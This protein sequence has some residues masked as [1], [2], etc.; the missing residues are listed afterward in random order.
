MAAVRSKDTTPELVVRRLVHAM[1]FRYRLHVES[2]PGC[3]DLVFPR[4]RKVILVNGCFWHMHTCRRSRIPSSRRGYWVKKLERNAS[5]DKRNLRLL[6][7]AG[8][9]VLVAWECQ[10]SRTKLARLKAR[11]DSFLR[12]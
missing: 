10:T 11:I 8:W 6:R 1:G 7:K 5:R 4:L 12:N 2:L 3:P 9:Y